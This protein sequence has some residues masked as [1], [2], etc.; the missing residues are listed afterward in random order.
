MPVNATKSALYLRFEDQSLRQLMATRT[1][2]DDQ[3]ELIPSRNKGTI[4]NCHSPS[5]D[6]LSIFSPDPVEGLVEVYHLHVIVEHVELR[7]TGDKSAEAYAD[8][9]DQHASLVEAVEKL[10]DRRDELV[11]ERRVRNMFL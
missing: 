7:V 5:H 6:L 3:F 10:L 11:I 8:K 4:S 1:F 2:M 9:A